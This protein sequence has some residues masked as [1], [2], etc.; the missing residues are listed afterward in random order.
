[1]QHGKEKEREKKKKDLARKRFYERQ[2]KRNDDEEKGLM[3]EKKGFNKEKEKGLK[4]KGKNDGCFICGSCDH[5]ANNCPQHTRSPWQI[6]G[7]EGAKIG[8]QIG[9]KSNG[10]EKVE[11]AQIGVR[12]KTLCMTTVLGLRTIG[13]EINGL[14]WLRLVFRWS[15]R[16]GGLLI[17]PLRF[18]RWEWDRHFNRL[19]LRHFPRLR[20]RPLRNTCNRLPR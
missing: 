8:T 18:S 3:K 5:W 9:T 16:L 15:V 4:G 20:P 10:L 6:E 17:G 13:T 1:M 2:R 14:R 11:R 12:T 7:S 19:R